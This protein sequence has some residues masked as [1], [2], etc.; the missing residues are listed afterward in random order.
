[1]TCKDLIL[2]TINKYEGTTLTN[3]PSDPGKATKFGISKRW[4]PDIDIVN[5]TKERAVEIYVKEYWN[6]LAIDDIAPRM[7]WKCFDLAVNGG[8]NFGHKIK[9]FILGAP[10]VETGMDI[11]I[12]RAKEH[13][14]SLILRNP[15]LEKFKAG[16]WKRLE[17]RGE[18]ILGDTIEKG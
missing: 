10:D 16:W 7:A 11:A 12:S 15:N 8:L 17:D 14:E 6:P 18:D 13:Y 2:R 3:D 4:H 9:D 1:M 5:L